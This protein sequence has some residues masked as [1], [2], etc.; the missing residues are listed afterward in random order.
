MFDNDHDYDNDNEP[1]RDFYTAPLGCLA[2]DRLR[3][4]PAISFD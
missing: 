3:P 2:F 4:H 1:P